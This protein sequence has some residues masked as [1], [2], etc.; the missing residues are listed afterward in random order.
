MTQQP[1]QPRRIPLG[2]T[3]FFLIVSL[4]TIVTVSLE[5]AFVAVASW[6]LLPLIMAVLVLMAIGV[7][8]AAVRLASDGE[9][10]SV[11][12]PEPQRETEPQRAP[13]TVGRPA[14]LGR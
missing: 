13:A 10:A 12:L 8:T 14:L 11:E 7:V 3:G 4:A 5:A 9:I 6:A 2:G 1:A